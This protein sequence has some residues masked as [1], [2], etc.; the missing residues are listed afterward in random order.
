MIR[1]RMGN[2]FASEKQIPDYGSLFLIKERSDGI[3][4]YG[5]SDAADATKLKYLVKAAIGSTCLFTDGSL[6]HKDL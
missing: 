4:D 5:G 3:N 6:Y 1:D 2:V